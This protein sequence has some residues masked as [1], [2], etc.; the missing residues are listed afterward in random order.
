MNLTIGPQ[1]RR[2]PIETN[3]A[4]LNSDQLR[5]NLATALGKNLDFI[6]ANVLTTNATFSPTTISWL[7]DDASD[8]AALPLAARWEAEN[9]ILIFSRPTIF[10]RNAWL[11]SGVIAG[12]LNADEVEFRSELYCH[13]LRVGDD[14]GMNEARFAGEVNFIYVSI[15]HDLGV[16][17][18]LFK[19]F[20][21]T[22]MNVGGSLLLDGAQFSEGARFDEVT[23]GKALKGQYVRFENR[24]KLTEFRGLKVDG[25]VD[26]LRAQFSGPVNFILSHIKGNF[27]AAGATF[28]DDHSFLELQSITHDSF[29]FNTDFGSMQVDGFAIF[30]NARFA[31]SVSFRNAQFGNFYLDG[32]HWPEPDILMT[33]T[34]DPTTNDLLRL[35]GMDFQTVRDVTS[36]HF[37]HTPAQLK[38][39]QVN[40]LA[41]FKNR[42]P[43]SFDIYAKL[44]SYFR[45]E[46]A[47]TLADQV[48]VNAKEREGSE[49]RGLARLANKVLDI[50]VGYGRKPWKAVVWSL[51]VIGMWAV[52]CRWWMVKKS[53]SRRIP[54]WGLVL[55]YSL[56][57]FLP[58]IDLKTAELLEF[59]TGKEWFRYLIAVE[60]ILGYILVP[61]WT[62][63]LAGLVR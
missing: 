40:L 36:G 52:F 28:D 9:Q 47:P 42:S 51:L 61:L 18:S 12:K 8:P 49:A 62:L 55:F 4:S 45:R 50:T 57:T 23:V 16:K 15:G 10:R 25:F 27:Q 31:R 2:W 30:E 48:F 41:M 11:D 39:S 29:T 35:E 46:G 34:N 56:G 19:N 43:Y 13:G 32:T 33:Y 20:D 37:L 38:E 53:S 21:A 60:K 59:R 5:T 22:G 58:I 3:I 14:F 24:D 26:L 7:F 44:E 17:N 63:A 6:Q 54:G 1:T